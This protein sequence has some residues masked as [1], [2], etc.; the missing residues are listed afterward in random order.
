[1][2][3]L[4]ID[5]L[6]ELRKEPEWFRA[7]RNEA[8]QLIE[9]TKLPSFQK[10]KY[11]DWDI[12]V[13]GT[14]VID[15]QPKF[16]TNADVYQYA[17]NKAQIKLPSEFL[18]KG[19]I[20]ED[21]EDALI[22]HEDIMKKY[23]M[24]KGLKMD[25]NR[26]LAEHVANLQS[27]VLVYVP[28]NVD[29]ETPLT[30]EYIQ[31]SRV[32]EDYV[33]H[34][35]I[36]TEA[37]S[38]LSYVE[39]LKT[40]GD[41]KNTANIVV[42]VIAGDGSRIHFASVDNLSKNTTAYMNRRGYLQR[43]SKIDWAMGMMNSGLTI[44]DFD[45]DLVGDGS[46]AELKVV[47]ISTSDQIQGIDTRVTNIGKNTIGHILQ[48]G[49]ALDASEL[50]FNG[51]GHVMKRSKGS[52]AQQESRI[53]M[54]SPQAR[55]DAN[56]ILL[57]DDNDVTAGHAASIGRVNPEQLYYLMSRGLQKRLAEKLV[58]RGFLAPVLDEIP[59]KEIRNEFSELIERKVSYD[60]EN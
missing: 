23:F 58:I 15:D 27:G 26:L 47:G 1:M 40:D 38:S 20:V 50:T 31:N 18:D 34:V 10:I 48:H 11:H 21:F 36:V 12:N 6:I 8:K 32:E 51:I 28:K 60:E 5:E 13:D 14:S 16:D 24:E 54:L 41:K 7:K 35:L 43:D 59:L 49:V 2:K 33:H 44:G 22:N 42:E 39:R 46:H 45:S 17:S 4:S 55:G 57:I 56:P 37:N 9:T 53:L 25:D 52:D 3:Q 19:V 30:C 29:L